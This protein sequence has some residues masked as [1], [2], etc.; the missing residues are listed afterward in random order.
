MVQSATMRQSPILTITLN[1]AVDVASHTAEVTPGP[2]LRLDRPSVDPGGGGIN[3]ARAIGILGGRARAFVALGG[4]TGAQLAFLLESAGIDL[5]RFPAPGDA[6]QS[7]SVTDNATGA[8]YRFILPGPD[9]GPEDTRAVLDAIAAEAGSAQALVVLSGSQPPGIP[10]DFPAALA[11]VLAGR[12]R[13]MIDTSGDPLHRLVSDPPVGAPP[14]LLRMDMAESIDLAGRP[15]PRPQDSADFAAS[16]VARGAA[17]MAV[18]ARGAE[19]SVLV[20]RGLRL[21][22]APPVVRVDSAVGAGDSFTG[23]FVLSLARG[24]TPEAALRHGTAAAAAAVMTGGTDL[25][26]IED[27]E[28]L[29]PGCRVSQV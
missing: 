7:L 12:A 1:P 26:R 18:L 9:W 14:D 3:V 20:A 8:Q 22:C 25:C 13:L 2:K 15:L 23:A 19:G 21:H 11:R 29:L 28:H 10:E 4:P 17:R 5:V 16:L 27:V 24:E 6:R